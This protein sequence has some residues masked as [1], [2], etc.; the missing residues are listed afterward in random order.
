MLFN[1]IDKKRSDVQKNFHFILDTYVLI[2]ITFPHKVSSTLKR[3]LETFTAIFFHLFSVYFFLIITYDLIYTTGVTSGI[4][5]TEFFQFLITNVIRL[6]FIHRSDKIVAAWSSLEKMVS[7]FPRQ[8]KQSLKP[9]ILLYFVLVIILIVGI[10]NG[11]IYPQNYRETEKQ[12]RHFFGQP[13]P[14]TY[15]LILEGILETIRNFFEIFTLGLTFV[16]LCLVYIELQ[17]LVTLSGTE[18]STLFSK[19]NFDSKL[20]DA[21]SDLLCKASNIASAVDNEFSPFLF[22]MIFLYILQIMAFISI[23]AIRNPGVLQSITFVFLTLHA[24][25]CICVVCFL[26]SRVSERY[27]EIKEIIMTSTVVRKEISLGKSGAVSIIGLRQILEEI[28]HNFSVTAM[29]AVQVDRMGI[30]TILCSIITYGVILYQMFQM[31]KE[32]ACL[33]S[34]NLTTNWSLVNS[35]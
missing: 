7:V 11:A 31:T 26:A 18:I 20:I 24:V 25:I 4:P 21:C 16:L 2:G 13:R 29:R 12:V 9:K 27:K 35:Q 10:S 3:R 23:F 1:M 6:H 8:S 17:W 14:N 22:Y 30:L 28:T 34:C 33:K 32:D 19:P 5:L 15:F